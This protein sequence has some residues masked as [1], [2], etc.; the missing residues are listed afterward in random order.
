MTTSTRELLE[1]ARLAILELTFEPERIAPLIADLGS[2][3][4]SEQGDD[5]AAAVTSWLHERTGDLHLRLVHEPVASDDPEA[6]RATW[7]RL[8][9]A[10]AG[11]I[12]GIDR[13]T[14]DTVLR[15]GEILCHP[16]D[17]GAEL[18]AAIALVAG[19]DRLV[20]DLRGCRGGAPEAVA[21]LCGGLLGEEP[22]HLVDIVGRTFTV[23]SWTTPWEHPR[24]LPPTC[25][26]AVLVSPTTFSG[27][28]ELAFVL[29]DLGRAR[30]IGER[31]RGG[32]NPRE[33]RRLDAEW[34]V[35][36][37]VA[38]TVSPRTGRSWEGVGVIPDLEVA[39]ADA[40]EHAWAR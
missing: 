20:V 40:L 38:H 37:P 27:G 28:E 14:T 11:G 1:T 17:S 19:A 5:L 25:P 16:A 33:A 6:E 8:S 3:P 24:R 21:V 22:E 23:Q 15:I 32:A 4:F 18:R 31:T 30:V 35:H 26:I 13:R 10:T 9:L 12:A 7:R 29:Q 2:T 36:V 39:A 34:A